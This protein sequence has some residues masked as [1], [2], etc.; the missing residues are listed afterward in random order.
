MPAKSPNPID[1]H[2]GER[3]RMA[4]TERKISRITLGE[5]IGLTDQQIQ[6]YETGIN[7]IGAS[8]LQHICTVLE[9][10]VAYLF[11]G[12]LGSPPAKGGMPEDVV[13]FMESEEGMRLVAAFERITDRKMRRGIVRLTDQIAEHMQAKVSGDVLEFKEPSD[14]T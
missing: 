11:E 10:P 4:R 12:A 9:I 13:D 6:K 1:I 3:M 8:R 2:V 7:R 14:D 5:A